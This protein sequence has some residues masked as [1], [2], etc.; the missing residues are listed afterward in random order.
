MYT[1]QFNLCGVFN[2]KDFVFISIEET[3]QA[4]VKQILKMHNFELEV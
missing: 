3:A 4:Q 1:N 2:I